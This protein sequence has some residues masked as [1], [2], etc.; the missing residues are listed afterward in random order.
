ML[1][2]D[3]GGKWNI[4]NPSPKRQELC[5]HGLFSAPEV[6]FYLVVWKE[7]LG[8]KGRKNINSGTKGQ[9]KRS[10]FESKWL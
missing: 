5:F 8:K 4:K 1:E 7:Y 9:K 3:F 6:V 10:L 2:S